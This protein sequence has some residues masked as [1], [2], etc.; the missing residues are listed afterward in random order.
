MDKTGVIVCGSKGRMGQAIVSLL[1]ENKSLVFIAGVDAGYSTEEVSRAIPPLTGPKFGSSFYGRLPTLKEA[2]DNTKKIKKRVIIDF[3]NAAASMK[4]AEKAGLS[5]VPIVI[6]ST[7]FTEDEIKKIKS[8]AGKIPVVLSG[9]MSLGINVL[10]SIVYDAS[11][12]LGPDYDCEIV[13]THHRHKKDAP[14]GTAMM[15]YKSVASQK[16]IDLSKGAVFGRHGGDAER[17][18]EEIGISSVRAG[19]IVGEHKVIFAGNEE[20]VEITHRAVSRDNFARG[21]IK[22]AAW[23]AGIK[24]KR[25]FFDMRDV[26]GLKKGN[27]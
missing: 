5:G 27:E 18:E 25:G 12:Y 11:K 24:Q 20:V 1:K 3:T 9:N 10:L 17:R 2:L 7:G 13:E 6:G 15:L 16:G 26:L 14:S 21:A 23:L 8:I 22:A 19:D 4:H